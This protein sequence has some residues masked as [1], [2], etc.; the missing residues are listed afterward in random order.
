[1]NLV[2]CENGHFYD[3][4]RYDKCPH[5]VGGGAVRD[6]NL[7]VPIM[8]SAGEAVTTAIN[9]PPPAE[10]TTPLAGQQAAPFAA[11]PG[12]SLQDAVRSATG[13]VPPV[14]GGKDEVTVSFYKRSIGSEPVVGWLVCVEGA[15]FGEDFR[16][17]SGRNFIGRAADMDVVIANDS[18]VSRE[19]HAVVVYEPKGNKFLVMPGESRELCYINDEI[20]L[21]PLDIKVHDML[22]VGD[23]KLMFVPCCSDTFNWDIVKKEEK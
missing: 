16:L 23:T 6:S 17:K 20:V 8:P 7:T 3:T 21:T 15:H 11:Q 19:K 9:S 5:C 2:K 14:G 22:T 18:A 12:M 13:G 10:V 1:M 4:N